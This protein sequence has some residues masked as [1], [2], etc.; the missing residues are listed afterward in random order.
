MDGW[1]DGWTNGPIDEWKDG[2]RCMEM[3][4]GM[5]IR[6]NFLAYD[7]DDDNDGN[8]TFLFYDSTVVASHPISKVKERKREATITSPLPRAR[9][10]RCL[11]LLAKLSKREREEEK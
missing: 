4:G 7:D 5:G 1:M 10:K 2:W 3:D 9:K 6:N 8:K 11:V